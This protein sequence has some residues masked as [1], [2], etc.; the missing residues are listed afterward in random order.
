M[1]ARFIVITAALLLTGCPERA[2]EHV[3]KANVLF[4]N[5]DLP[6][7][8][9]EY[10]IALESEKELP[11]ALEGLG[12]IA[13]EKGDLEQAESWYRR[14]AVADP[15]AVL[16][17][18]RLAI[19][20]SQRGRDVEATKALESAVAIDPKDAFGYF[21][22]GNLYQ[23]LGDPKKAEAMQRKALAA[24]PDHKAARLALANLEIDDE[25]Y[26]EAER[27]LARLRTSGAAS[28]AEYGLA[29]LAAAT[30]KASEAAE[31]LDRVLSFGVTHPAKIL[32]DP[33]FAESWSN[34]GMAAIQKR[35]EAKTATTTR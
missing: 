31:H 23:K 17:L 8:E 1:R 7:A 21:S 16:P 34:A 13:F 6:G 28:L 9:K 33:I 4:S 12:D 20:L 24:E 22:L 29:R 35:L 26:E 15:K 30:G 5:H 18:H 32:S 14:A 27:D 19:V 11:P 2:E 25:R 3:R 10:G